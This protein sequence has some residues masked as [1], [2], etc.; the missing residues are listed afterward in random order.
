[1]PIL[2]ID[3]GNTRT[4]WRCADEAGALPAPELPCPVAG[5]ERV[6]VASVLRNREGI[7]AEIRRR[8]NVEAEFAATSASLAGVRC[9]YREPHRLGVDR[10]LAVAAAWQRTHHALAVISVGTAACADFVDADGRH[11]GGYIAPGLRLLAD[12]LDRRT[13]DVRPYPREEPSAGE[14]EGP[15][16]RKEEPS[17]GEREGRTPRKEEPSAGE[18]EGPASRK[19]EYR[20]EP[21][22]DTQQAVAAGTFL[23]LSAFV[24]AAIGRLHSRSAPPVA[25]FLTGGDAALL[26]PRLSVDVRCEPEL[27]LDGLAIALP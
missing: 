10:W 17:A 25:V 1:M 13:A 7:A 8:F 12:A 27:V 14:R 15:A 6:R 3:M 24:D 16:P 4:K 5:P 19:E 11:A 9:G 18:R 26:A 21:G 22:T 23:M 20:L 2:D